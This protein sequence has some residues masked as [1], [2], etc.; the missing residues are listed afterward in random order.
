MTRPSTFLLGAALLSTLVLA[1]DAAASSPGAKT[2]QSAPT[3]TAAERADRALGTVEVRAI[4]VQRWLREARSHENAPRIRCL[5][6]LLSQ[7]HAVERQ[8]RV[9][10]RRVG[11][12]AERGAREVVGRG[13]ARLELFEKRSRFVVE[14]AYWCGK[15]R[16]R[17]VKV[18]TG[19]RVRVIKPKLP[20]VST[21][22]S[23]KAAAWR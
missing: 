23:S 12:A 13:L 6:R 18:P 10:E 1:S 21:A 4:Q 14:E 3:P 17:R 11:R 8:A 19:Y 16:S 22:P 15:K 7:A 9:E 2:S 20:N 5:D